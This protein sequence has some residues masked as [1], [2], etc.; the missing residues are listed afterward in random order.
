MTLREL[1][2]DQ[3]IDVDKLLDTEVGTEPILATEIGVTADLDGK[4]T[5]IHISSA[6]RS[7]RDGLEARA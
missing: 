5:T 4:R 6:P 3:R 2:A 1:L 7:M